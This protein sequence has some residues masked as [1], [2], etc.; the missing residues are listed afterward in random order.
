MKQHNMT[1]TI[2][3]L[4]F[5][6]A[7]S[8]CGGKNDTKDNTS[9]ETTAKHYDNL[10]TGFTYIV[11]YDDIRNDGGELGN[12]RMA[13]GEFSTEITK[14]SYCSDSEAIGKIYGLI[15]TD[16]MA[17]EGEITFDN[18]ADY[19]QWNENPAIHLVFDKLYF[20]SVYPNGKVV[21]QTFYTKG[22][23]YGQLA[24]E[25]YQENGVYPPAISDGLWQY[26]A[27]DGTYSELSQILL[28]LPE[29]Q[30]PTA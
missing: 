25:Y 11:P 6:L 5:L 2:V 10:P 17:A 9:S 19:D 23:K 26:A 7:L 21:T 30:E 12:Y 14:N 3:I 1:F 18:R 27:S 24:D 16:G 22:E 20:V 29:E 28:A 4:A 15:D 8:G 13:D